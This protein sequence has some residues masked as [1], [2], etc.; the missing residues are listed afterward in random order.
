MKERIRQ[1]RNYTDNA[2][3]VVKQKGTKERKGR[4]YLSSCR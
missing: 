2:E 1:R 4:S 3:K